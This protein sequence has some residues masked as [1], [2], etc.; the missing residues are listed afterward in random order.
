MQIILVVLYRLSSK[1]ENSIAA[2]ETKGVSNP[3]R[4]HISL[5][6][7]TWTSEFGVTKTYMITE[8]KYLKVIEEGTRCTKGNV[9]KTREIS[10]GFGMKE[11][12]H[13][14]NITQNKEGVEKDRLNIVVPISVSNGGARQE[15]EEDVKMISRSSVKILG[16][17]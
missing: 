6:R 15:I 14:V 10:D 17:D 12:S 1:K 2:T 9:R 4:N 16:R 11:E 13:L 7:M 3:E 8:R 5:C